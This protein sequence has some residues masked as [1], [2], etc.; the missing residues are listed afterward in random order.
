M[1]AITTSGKATTSAPTSVAAAYVDIIESQ[2]QLL[3]QTDRLMATLLEAADEGK[4]IDS[5][6]VRAHVELVKNLKV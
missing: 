1:A 4:T 5:S 2:E 6:Q 3:T